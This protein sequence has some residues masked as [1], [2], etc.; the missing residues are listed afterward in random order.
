MAS[1]NENE[2]RPLPPGYI[3]KPGVGAVP[4]VKWWADQIREGE[5]FRKRFAQE[6]KW[7]LWRAF[8]RGTYESDVLPVNL[9]YAFLRSM[10]PRVYFRDPGVS[11]TPRKAGPLH[12]A[13]AQILQRVDNK[14]IRQMKTKDR[15]KRSIQN[16][17]MFGTG[18]LKL[19]FGAQYSLTP[20][21][22]TTKAPVEERSGLRWRTEYRAGIEPNM[23]WL[24]SVHPG[25]LVVPAGLVEYDDAPWVAHMVERPIWDVMNDTRLKDARKKLKAH[26]AVPIGTT[27]PKAP[28]PV[29]RAVETVKLYEIRDLRTARV[30]IIAPENLDEDLLFEPDEMQFNGSPSLFPVIFNVDDEAFWGVPDSQ[31][32]DPQQREINEIN[33]QIMKH[34]RVSL[35]KFLYEINAITQEELEKA[36]SEDV[37]AGVQVSDID[38]VKPIQISQIPQDL[39]QA[40]QLIWE[41]VREVFGFSRNQSGQFASRRGDTTA[42]EAQIVHQASEIRLDERRDIMADVLSDIVRS[43]HRIIFAHWR[44][45]QVID[46]VGPE[47]VPIFVRFTGEM[48]KTGQYEVKIDPDNGQ[49]ESRAMRQ[50]KAFLMYERLASNPLIDPIQLTAFLLHELQGVEFDGMMRGM[51]LLGGGVSPETALT[52]QEFGNVLGAA[53][54]RLPQLLQRARA[55]MQGG[56]DASL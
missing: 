56:G 33:T 55:A 1:P 10:I 12:A 26:R 23:P 2:N 36:L 32:L 6:E 46:L 4:D 44:N 22:D 15:M 48:L 43:M 5:A 3:R 11:I 35:I 19:G 20:D 34:R 53:Q 27:V 18:C 14:L 30:M 52:P 13:L 50:Q 28:G 29:Q 47:G 9:F 51:G 45:E 40:R 54:Q 38:K 21:A 31:I 39:I 41:T 42:T 24:G 17:F 8:Y 37:L 25:H 16:A 49:P 7:P